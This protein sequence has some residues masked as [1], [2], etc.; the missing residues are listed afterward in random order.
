MLFATINL[1]GCHGKEKVVRVESDS[2]TQQTDSTWTPTP[3]A[4][5]NATRLR[6][7]AAGL[8]VVAIAGEAYGIFGV[9]RHTP[10][11][12]VLLI[13]LIVVIGILAV[14]GSLLWKKANR[15]DPAS[16]Q[17]TVRFF[18]HN[19]LGAIVTVIAFL[20]LIILILT[21]KDMSKNQ[22]MLA[23]GIGA[24]VMVAA[25]A[26]GVD[27]SPPSTEQ[28]TAESSQVT[29]ITGNDLVY[30]TKSGKVFHLCEDVS[31]V[32]LK[33]KDN[34]IYSGTVADAHAAGKDRMTKQIASETKQC[35]FD[36]P[37]S[38]PTPSPTAAE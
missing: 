23:G 15:L 31:A 27:W 36:T 11:N 6:L 26:I 4:T 30:W 16:K 32:N 33:S 8:W 38:A 22:K 28:Y 37:A 13:V 18:I 24:V 20:P 2:A 7:I 1:R 25:T 17:D 34:K 29:G 12:M 5:S 21:N 19:Q 10:V 3:E 9:L 35:G 14:A